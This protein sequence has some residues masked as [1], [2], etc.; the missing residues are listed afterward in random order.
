M[1]TSKKT[2]GVT[3]LSQGIGAG[4]VK[5]LRSFSIALLRLRVRSSRRVRRPSS[6]KAFCTV[7]TVGVPGAKAH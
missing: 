7:M 6:P 1:N 2:G 4:I 3:G 5:A